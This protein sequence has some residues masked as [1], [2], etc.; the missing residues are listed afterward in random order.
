MPGRFALLGGLIAF[1][2]GVVGGLARGLSVHAATA[3]FAAF[4]VGIPAAI[5]GGTAG[6]LLGCAAAGLVAVRSRSRQAR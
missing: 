6:A 2:L 4:E 1:V 5:L 3:W